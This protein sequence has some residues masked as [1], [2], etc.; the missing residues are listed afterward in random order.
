V[1]WRHGINEVE[2]ADLPC[3]GRR[4]R[5]VWLKQRWRCPNPARRVVTF[6]ESDERIAADRAAITD[7]AGRWATFQV[8]RH[9]RSV[10][11]VAIDLGCDWHTVMDAVI[12]FG[13][14]L[15][16]DPKRIGLVTAIGL[17]EVLFCRHGP[18]R[19]RLWSTQ[20]VDV[21]RGQLLDVVPGRDAA[22]TC[23]WFAEQPADWC[24][25]IRWATLDLSGPHRSVFDTMLRHAVQIA[26]PFHVVK[27]ANF[28]LDETRRRV[29]NET[30][31]H[32]GRKTDPLYRIRKLMTI[33]HERLDP[34]NNDEMRGLLDAGDPAGLPD[35]DTDAKEVVR[36]IY[37]I[38]DPNMASEFVAQLGID[39][40]DESC[41]PEVQ[42]L[43][44]TISRWRHQIAAWHQAR[45]T[46]G[47]TEAV[48]NLI[49][50][51]K[52]VAFGITNWTNYRTRALLYA[53]RPNWSLLNTPR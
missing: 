28:V 21:A 46:N 36:E 31:G 13:A 3:F 52:R 41:P 33:A 20:V 12:H 5:L 37:T 34:A 11:E 1:A 17:D 51:I 39:L 48:N 26:D 53:G 24:A 32:R 40:Q 16:D 47:P 38:E 50:R 25:K 8:G 29:Q 2:L 42:R 44:R 45:H 7:R 4:T 19:H 18:F 35:H 15:I 30:C 22:S 23:A 49:K 9:G 14:P 43:G 10:S 27:L 6:V